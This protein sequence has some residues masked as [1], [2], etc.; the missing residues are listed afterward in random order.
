MQE[1]YGEIAAAIVRR[2]KE[3]N[4]DITETPQQNQKLPFCRLGNMFFAN[5]L[6]LNPGCR[7][8]TVTVEITCIATQTREDANDLAISVEKAITTIGDI[9]YD[10][11]ILDTWLVFSQNITFSETLCF[12]YSNPSESNDLR[13]GFA[14]TSTYEFKVSQ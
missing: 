11:L 9:E 6:Q 3:N 4:I 8:L 2:L 14:C 10:R 5:T 7:E 12:E 13:E 1:I